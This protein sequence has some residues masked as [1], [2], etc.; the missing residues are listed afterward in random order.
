MTSRLGY[1]LTLFCRKFILK[2]RKFD[3]MWLALCTAY[4][5]KLNSSVN[6]EPLA[7]SIYQF[8]NLHVRLFCISPPKPLSQYATM[9]ML[10]AQCFIVDC[11]YQSKRT[12]FTLQWLNLLWYWSK[13]TTE[14]SMHM[15]CS[16]VGGWFWWA[17]AMES[18][19]QGPQTGIC[20]KLKVENFCC[21]SVYWNT[22]YTRRVTYS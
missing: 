19:T 18:Y 6:F 3:C 22:L 10:F 2:M 12:W 8:V 5:S 15:Y 17:D 20:C 7:C 1:I 13:S 16:H 4:S 21:S 9:H 11:H 14:H